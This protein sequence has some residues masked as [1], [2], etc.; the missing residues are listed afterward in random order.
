MFSHNG[1]VSVRQ[2]EMMLILQMF[3]T[4]VLLLPRIAAN[5]VGRVGYILP[6]IALV[7]GV[8]YVYA[9]ISLIDRFRGDTLV[10][11]APKILPST[12]AYSLI[13]LFAIKILITTGL[14]I[15]MFGEMVSQVMLSK[16]PLS[17]IILT[18]LIAT[19]YLVKSGIEATSRMAEI[20]IY[21]IFIPLVI[22]F[23]LIVVKADYRQL[24][25][26]FETDAVSI[27]KGAFMIS[28]SFM[29]IEFMLMLAALMKQPQK[30]KKAMLTAVISIA[31]V[32]SLV[33]I[34]TYV[35]IGFN[36]A[37]RQVWPVLTL[38]QSVQFPGSL[39][40]NQQI[41][42]MTSW[43]F[44]IFMYVSGGIYFTSLIGSRAFKFKRENLFVLP[45]IPIIYFIAIFP[46]S[47][48]QAY[49]YYVTFQRYFG[50]WFL[51][52]IP[53]GLIVIAKVRKVGD[54][55]GEV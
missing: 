50:I 17:V 34:L 27:G 25:P 3:N 28:L 19:A 43:V 33:I 4:S 42:M 53:L 52:P 8:S 26:F 36:E 24:M 51:V 18:M 30:A 41:L 5:R 29:P 35:G 44:S 39:I 1:K 10:E 12:L 55:D 23:G 47:L 16:T 2:V 9:I 31:V 13:I 14:E 21:F 48:T 54:K 37:K 6:I 7:F 49:Q 32:E 11:L 40:E 15:R 38:M 46:Q 45:V 22:V 20:L